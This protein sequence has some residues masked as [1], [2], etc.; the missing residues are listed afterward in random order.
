MSPTQRRGAPPPKRA[1]RGTR[2]QG[3]PAPVPGSSKH[4]PA[5]VALSLLTF[6]AFWNSFESGF[7]LDNRGL[8]LND[9]RL[10]EATAANLRLIWQHTYWWPTGEGGVFRPFTTLTYLF[11]YAILGNHDR[12][13]GYHAVNLLIH[14][15]NALMIYALATRF[16]RRFWPAF[17]IAA[18][19]GVHPVLTE[20]VTNIVGRADLLAAT[21][22]IAGFLAYLQSIEAIGWRRWAWLGSLSAFT[23]MG[24]FS[25]ENAVVL[26]GVIVV[27]ELAF[28][29]RREWRQGLAG[30]L[31][32]LI[33]MAPMFYQRSVVLAASLPKEVP[34]TDNPILGA[35]F[36]AGRLTAI[37]V[38]VRYLW[39]MLWPARLSSDYSWS[40]I[41][42]AHGGV[43]DCIA[44]FAVLALIPAMVFL[45]RRSRGVF[46][47][48]CIALAWIAP[49][50][51]VLF[52]IGTIM[53]ERF[54]YVPLLGFV[55]CVVLGIYTA[56][57]Q[58]R[59]PAYAPVVVCLLLIAALTGRTWVRNSDWKDDLSI[60]TASV[61]TSPDSFKT[62]DLLANVL[63]ASDPTHANIGRVIEESEKS[64]AILN[65]LP[66]NRSLPDPYQLAGTCYLYRG[67]YR[68]AVAALL[69]F[70][71]IEKAAFA[72]FQSKLSQSGPSAESAA[73]ITA[74]RQGDAYTLLSMAYLRAGD[75]NDA[76]DAAAQ[77]RTLHP[78]SL[79]LYRQLA[80]IALAKGRL[81]EAAACYIEGAFV[82]SDGSLRQDLVAMYRK[83]LPRGNCA[84]KPGPR[85]P[86]LNTA[87]PL[88][89]ADLCNAA[90]STVK[91][92]VST[93]QNDL[94]LTRKKMFVEEFGCPN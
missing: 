82:L 2:R 39:L 80:D 3:S 28:R 77:A 50:C 11:N 26:P 22:L 86:A 47:L 8:L 74:A 62:H 32:T 91:T 18:I 15:A 55:T 36:R 90:A 53:A 79:Q 16:I 73:R 84:L 42:I 81:D 94:A 43:K 25:K 6:L 54:L 57:K 9:P 49:V 64:L 67:D 70:I 58:L 4:L 44:L 33:S 19:W 1:E 24:V 37:D 93:D 45:Y 29:K 52:P 87:C 89:H 23:F 20:A 76:S 41:P 69:R 83:K 59:M 66:D 56:T 78:L 12:P 38:L 40:E 17:F 46:F 14:L 65:P 88:V 30:L 48:S 60:A 68:K 10:R 7:V 61:Q 27:Y 75:T 21:G 13:A 5:V 51:N 34:F 85:G 72:E 92:L 63:Y 35:G 31:V 71:R